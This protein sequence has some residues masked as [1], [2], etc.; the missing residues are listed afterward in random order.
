VTLARPT[1]DKRLLEGAMMHAAMTR[2]IDAFMAVTN[3]T[4]WR[5]SAP[6]TPR[7][8]GL[9]AAA[10]AAAGPFV[11]RGGVRQAERTGIDGEQAERTGI[12]VDVNAQGLR[13]LSARMRTPPRPF[14]R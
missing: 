10:A 3:I 7:G 9:A 11:T 12:D 13:P 5:L 8:V 2:N 14:C 4:V 1:Q 6:A